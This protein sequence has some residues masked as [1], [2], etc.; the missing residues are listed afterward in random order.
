MN[1]GAD[2][3]LRPGTSENSMPQ[4]L[5]I[6]NMEKF[7]SPFIDFVEEHLPDF[8]RHTFFCF[9]EATPYPIRRRPNTIFESDYSRLRWAFAAAIRQMYRAEKIILHGL[10]NDQIIQLL[11]LQPWLLKK[12]YWAIW[13]ADLYRYQFVERQS[14]WQK[15]TIARRI[16]IKR[17]G[18]LMTYV[19]GDV[20]L[21]RKWYGAKGT[22]HECL[23]YPSNLFV[24][25]R[26]RRTQGPTI[27]IQIGNSADP[28]NEYFE[29]FDLLK[30]HKKSDIMI[31]ALLSY[32]DPAHAQ[33]VATEG[34]R[35]FGDKFVAI[36]DFMELDDYYEFLGKIDIAIFNHRRQ[37]GMGNIVN[38]LGMGK[39]V[40]IRNDVTSWDTLERLG[41]KTYD[42]K[43]FDLNRIEAQVQK[44][45]SEIIQSYFSPQ[46]LCSQ[47]TEIFEA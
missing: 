47:L 13:G 15:K 2:A 16:V 32:G 38:L 45:N 25:R 37:Q 28:K 9:G 7:I 4:V 33:K 21:A 5:H 36:T 18:H 3:G 30:P 10:W 17:L 23:L 26:V 6:M 24:P 43:N 34:A 1:E 22:F 12:C 41:I 35:L 46:V 8:D 19:K 44:N 20:D 27:N 14:A 29:L 31:Y 39:K 40:Y 11:S 42:I